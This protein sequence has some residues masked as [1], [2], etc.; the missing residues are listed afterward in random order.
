[1]YSSGFNALKTIARIG[2]GTNV[3]SQSMSNNE[4]HPGQTLVQ[5]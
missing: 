3:L 1:M 5:T 2:V 4:T